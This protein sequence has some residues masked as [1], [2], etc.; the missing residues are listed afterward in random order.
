MRQSLGGLQ[1]DAFGDFS[2]QLAGGLSAEHDA[3]EERQHVARAFGDL[4][5]VVQQ[6]GPAVEV[7]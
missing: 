7:A 6:V 4:P 2:N 5:L 1:G 3:H